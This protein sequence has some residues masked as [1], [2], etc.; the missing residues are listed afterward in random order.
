MST[1]FS[2][3]NFQH[4]E[5]SQPMRKQDLFP[6]LS[7]LSEHSFGT[8]GPYIARFSW[9]FESYQLCI[10]VSPGGNHGEYLGVTCRNW[11]IWIMI[12]FILSQSC[13]TKGMLFFDALSNLGNYW[14]FAA[15][16]L[17]RFFLIT[18]LF[19]CLPHANA[20]GINCF[21]F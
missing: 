8:S 7:D 2:L 10:L 9:N 18:S 17:I 5:D 3:A 21:K 13:N 12:N 1:D 14:S 6:P 20:H 11:M 15:V 16:I 4:L 19:I